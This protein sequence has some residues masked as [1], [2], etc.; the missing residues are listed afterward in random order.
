[1]WIPHC[2]F[3]KFTVPEINVHMI[4]P[5][6]TI[7]LTTADRSDC[8]LHDPNTNH[9]ETQSHWPRHPSLARL[10]RILWPV[11][12]T[13]GL[14]HWSVLD[15]LGLTTDDPKLHHWSH[16]HIVTYGRVW[17]SRIQY[18]G[19][20]HICKILTAGQRWPVSCRARWVWHYIT[21][22]HSHWIPC[23]YH[24]TTFVSLQCLKS[25]L[26]WFDHY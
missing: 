6:L 12:S 22:G 24:I 10:H 1:M 21:L 2:H 25:M 16:A 19:P 11:L 23:G 9:L 15:Q 18:S 8:M 4:W 5:L 3:C 26:T 7:K 14:D 20:Y 13:Q 17:H